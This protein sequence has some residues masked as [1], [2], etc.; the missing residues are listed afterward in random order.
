MLFPYTFVLW[1]FLGDAPIETTLLFDALFFA[2]ALLCNVLFMILSRN[3]HPR[4]LI[5]SALLVKM[6][7][8][9]AYVYIFI[10][11][12]FA[13]LLFFF[14]IPLILMYILYDYLVLLLSSS[15]SVF[16]LIKNMK[17][18]KTFSTV[19]LICQFFF[20]ADFISL[21]VLWL[22]SKKERVE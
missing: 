21:F 15:V 4:N 6:V 5:G 10:C 22:L 2:A 3:D 18:S 19:T 17:N 8:I 1:D 12:A 20:C 14:S 7:H 16:S 13:S 11:G 9:P